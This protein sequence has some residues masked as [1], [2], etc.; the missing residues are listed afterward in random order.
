MAK[1]KKVKSS[2]KPQ[3]S[4]LTPEGREIPDP[5]PLKPALSRQRARSIRDHVVDVVR[6]ENFRRSMEDQGQET[7]EDADDFDVDDDI[8][9]S[10]PYE[11]FF[12]GEYEQLRQAR[13]EASLSKTKR[14]KK[15]AKARQADNPSVNPGP[16]ASDGAGPS[17]KAGPA[18]KVASDGKAPLP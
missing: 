18:S 9:P 4:G 2:G 12:E 17:S 1:N 8:D 5:I 3:I 13:I 6:S 15:R 10:S 11:E 16:D 14:E 7:F